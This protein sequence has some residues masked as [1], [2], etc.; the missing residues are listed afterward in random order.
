MGDQEA[1]V[2]DV[3]AVEFDVVM[4]DTGRGEGGV[5]VP[6]PCCGAAEGACAGVAGIALGARVGDPGDERV[7]FVST[8][9]A[10]AGGG[11]GVPARGVGAAQPVLAGTGRAVLLRCFPAYR[12]SR[13]IGSTPA[14]L[15]PER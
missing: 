13:P 2:G 5:E 3:D 7:E 8:R 12:T 1:Q 14:M 6:A 11:E 10:W 9:G 4:D 15:S